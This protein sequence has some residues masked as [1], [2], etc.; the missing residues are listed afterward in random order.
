[1][2]TRKIDVT[3]AA[4]AFPEDTKPGGIRV[5]IIG[6]TPVEP[7]ILTAAPYEIAVPAGLADGDYTVAVDAMD[8]AGNVLAA[9]PATSFTVKSV[10]VDIPQSVTVSVVPAP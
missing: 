9:G 1:M 6:P 5:S 2:T 3:V 10:M 4:T 7:Q 8:A